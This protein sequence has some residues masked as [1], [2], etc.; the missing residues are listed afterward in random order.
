M[1]ASACL[2][3]LPTDQNYA[4]ICLRD[5]SLLSQI[6]TTSTD[7][8]SPGPLAHSQRC[9]PTLVDVN[10]DVGPVVA[11][12]CPSEMFWLGLM[13]TQ[14]TTLYNTYAADKY[15]EVQSYE[16][17]E[18]QEEVGVARVDSGMMLRVR[19]NR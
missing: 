3:S 14:L 12:L 9:R 8:S 17:G 18:Q 7:G 13:T 5:P 1:V 16:Q 19:S 11:C 10:I 4:N 2:L 6:L 15:G